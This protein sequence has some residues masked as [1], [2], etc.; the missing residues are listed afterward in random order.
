VLRKV[1]GLTWKHK[2]TNE[3]LYAMCG[4]KP[5]SVQVINARWRLFGHVL[6]MNENVP[7][8]Q[9]MTL[10]FEG[11]GKNIKGRQGNFCS[12]ASMLSDDYK[13]TFNN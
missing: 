7:A 11:L 3:D 12:I 8:R 2:V 1:I 9:A 6:R 13:K 10:Y 4:Y 5:A